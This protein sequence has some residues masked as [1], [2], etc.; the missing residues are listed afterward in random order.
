MSK[1][2]LNNPPLKEAIFE[3]RWDPKKIPDEVRKD[4]Q[5][6]PGMLK[7]KV[8]GVYGYHE[9]VNDTG[10]PLPEEFANGIVQNRF[11]VSKDGW[12]VMQIGSGVFTINDT[13]QGEKYDWSDFK[14]KCID[15]VNTLL[16]ILP[17]S[18]AIKSVNLRYVNAIEFDFEENNVFDFLRDK[19]GLNVSMPEIVSSNEKLESNPLNLNF[20]LVYPSKTPA[21]QFKIQI[22]SGK[23][24]G[25]D[26]LIF[27]LDFL[28]NEL[29]SPSLPDDLGDWL[30]HSHKQIE[31]VFFD[32]IKNLDDIIT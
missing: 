29:N 17:I 22:A 10:F 26:A 5:L 14:D 18:N 24:K 32:L 9:L 6:I 7:D 25:I 4:I 11:R 27:N 13:N 2:S 31:D 23:D 30:E 20:V 21:G 12:P 3:I 16:E 28:S 15:G 8:K 1:R 19:M